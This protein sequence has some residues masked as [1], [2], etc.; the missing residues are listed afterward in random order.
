VPGRP[1]GRADGRVRR[2]RGSWVRAVAAVLAH[3]RLWTTAVR[4]ATSA[5]PPRWW[6][7]P[8]FLPVPD[9]AYL[10]FRLETHYGDD[11]APDAGDLVRYLEWCRGGRR[12]IAPEGSRGPR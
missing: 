6:R 2:A 9:R 10:R 12:G 1:D 3:P 8:P 4:Q 11:A 5:T 7:R